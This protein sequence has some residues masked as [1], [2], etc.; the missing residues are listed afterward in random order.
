MEE[1]SGTD[2]FHARSVLMKNSKAGVVV[3]DLEF[4]FFYQLNSPECISA[5][6]TNLMMVK[7]R[8]HSAG[9]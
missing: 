9:W 5:A 4:F 2:P 7:V 1:R 8:N 6:Y 3:E